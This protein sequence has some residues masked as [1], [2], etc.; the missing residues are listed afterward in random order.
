MTIFRLFKRR[1]LYPY[2]RRVQPR[3]TQDQKDRRVEFARKYQHHDWYNTMFTD[4]SDFPLYPDVNPQNERVWDLDGS[5]IPPIPKVKHSPKLHVWGG[6]SAFWKTE[7]Y[8]YEGTV[9]TQKYLDILKS[10]KPLDGSDLED[11]FDEQKWTFQ[12]DGAP[13]HSSKA[14]TDWLKNFVPA[15]IPCGPTRLGG[16]WPSSSPDLNPIEHVWAIMKARLAENPPETM[17]DLKVRIKEEW[18]AISVE[19]LEKLVGSMKKRL[20]TVIDKNGGYIGK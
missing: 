1:G 16:I 8:F 12:Q 11:M 15:F 17:A 5:N 2:K 6:I 20:Q 14:A 7:L 13:A 19:T 9:D 4:E 3:L 10:M 18:A